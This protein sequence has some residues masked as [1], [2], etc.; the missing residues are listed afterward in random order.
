MKFSGNVLKGEVK[1]EVAAWGRWLNWR[2]RWLNTREVCV[3][4]TFGKG[5]NENTVGELLSDDLGFVIEDDSE[6][7]L[8][9]VATAVKLYANGYVVGSERAAYD[10][11]R[12]LRKLLGAAEYR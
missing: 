5:E 12:D 4:V 11:K 9:R 3:I 1:G 10:L 6:T 8:A 7:T 2:L